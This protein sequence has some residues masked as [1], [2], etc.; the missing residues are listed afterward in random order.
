MTHTYI[1]APLGALCAALFRCA[2]TAAVPIGSSS[3]S[4]QSWAVPTAVLLSAQKLLTAVLN[5]YLQALTNLLLLLCSAVVKFHSYAI[6]C[7]FA[8]QALQLALSAAAAAA[9][10][11]GPCPRQCS[12][13]PNGY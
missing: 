11:A 3:S 1:G 2:C 6:C 5:A 10:T 9:S 8:L 13:L 7:C 12:C 4:K